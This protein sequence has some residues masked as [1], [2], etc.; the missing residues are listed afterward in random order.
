MGVDTMKM[1]MYYVKVLFDEDGKETGEIE[2]RFTA[3]ISLQ[4][5]D[6]VKENFGKTIDVIFPKLG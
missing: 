4:D 5:I 6:F 1:K 3:K 2:I